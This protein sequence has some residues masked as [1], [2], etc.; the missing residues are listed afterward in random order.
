MCKIAEKSKNKNDFGSVMSLSLLYSF[1]GEREN[2]VRER[3][4]AQQGRREG[5]PCCSPTLLRAAAG[6]LRSLV[7]EGNYESLSVHF[8]VFAF[9]APSIAE[10][11]PD[12]NPSPNISPLHL[13]FHGH[14]RRR[15]IVLILRWRWSLVNLRLPTRRTDRSPTLV[16]RRPRRVW[17]FCGRRPTSPLLSSASAAGCHNPLSGSLRSVTSEVA[18]GGRGSVVI[19]SCPREEAGVEAANKWGDR[20][21]RRRDG[22]RR[23]LACPLWIRQVRFRYQII[24]VRCFETPFRWTPRCAP[25]ENFEI[26]IKNPYVL[27]GSGLNLCMLFWLF[28]IMVLSTSLPKFAWTFRLK[29]SKSMHAVLII[30]YY[31]S[32]LYLGACN[33]NCFTKA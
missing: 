4:R 26:L 13:S 8:Y 10:S 31:G 3:E 32:I 11:S 5:G 24:V 28:I 20:G 23:L 25:G 27:D 18:A 29:W 33:F 9:P 14:R 30:Y 21:G 19:G 1:E 16:P 2:W 6:I 12:R 7:R 15:R 22:G 17:N